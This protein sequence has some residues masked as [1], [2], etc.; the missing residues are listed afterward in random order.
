[1]G[2]HS[3]EGRPGVAITP[4]SSRLYASI[5]GSFTLIER[6]SGAPMKMARWANTGHARR[7]RKTNYSII[8]SALTKM[9]FGIDKPSNFASGR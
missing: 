9:E 7:S 6:H 4:A 1:M 3:L 5:A 8:S 2:W